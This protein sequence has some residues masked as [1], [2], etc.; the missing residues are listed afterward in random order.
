M[1][2]AFLVIVGAWAIY[3]LATIKKKNLSARKDY[4]D[5]LARRP[6]SVFP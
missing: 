5:S 6:K 2:I 4:F 1:E 3:E